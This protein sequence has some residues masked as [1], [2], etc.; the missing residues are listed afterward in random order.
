MNTQ[1]RVSFCASNASSDQVGWVEREERVVCTMQ[2]VLFFIRFYFFCFLKRVFNFLVKLCW[3][4]KKNGVFKTEYFFS[5]SSRVFLRLN[6][7]RKNVSRDILD[8]C[9]KTIFLLL[10]YLTTNSVHAVS[11]RVLLESKANNESTHWDVTAQGGLELIR[12]GKISDGIYDHLLVEHRDGA[13]FVNNRR[14]PFTQFK[15]RSLDGQISCNGTTYH[16]SLLFVIDANVLLLINVVDLEDYI[17]SVLR[18]ESWPG[19][20]LEVN[21]ALAI[22]CRSYVLAHIEQN[23][24]IKKPYHVCNTNKHQTYRGMH[25]W[26]HLRDAVDQTRHMALVHKDKPIMA[27]FD[28]CCAGVIPANMPGIDFIKAPYLKRTYACTFCKIYKIYSWKGRYRAKELIKTLRSAGYKC[29]TIKNI[30]I[31]RTNKAGLAD[32]VRIT[33]SGKPITLNAKQV[34]RIFKKNK[35]FLFDVAKK[36]S[37]FI[38]DGKGYGHHIGLCQWGARQMI[39]QGKTY[40]DV[41]TFYYPGTVLKRVK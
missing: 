20:P 41:L 40:K 37:T 15:C 4:S 2:K 10:I 35:S 34:Y 24:K 31:I 8:T 5:R 33:T 27:M 38:F 14:C 29:S 22:A 7:R 25:G 13:I 9:I 11:V 30:E 21:K 17:F 23:N 3:P 32:L 28:S 19:W 1:K 39:A 16:G 26:L 6:N 36:G 18:T 12:R